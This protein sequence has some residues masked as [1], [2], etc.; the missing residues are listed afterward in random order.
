MS[1]LLITSIKDEIWDS[2]SASI[3]IMKKAKSYEKSI[4]LTTELGHMNTISYLPN[5]RYKSIKQTKYIMRLYC[6][7]KILYLGLLII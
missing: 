7:G 3:N 2:Y 5:P 4:V 1:P 6:R